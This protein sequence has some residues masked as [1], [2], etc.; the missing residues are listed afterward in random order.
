[1]QL[2]WHA[3]APLQKY[4][5]QAIVGTAQAPPLQA[6]AILRVAAPAGQLALAQA[7]PSAYFWQPPA[8]S[9]LPF[10]PQ[11]AAP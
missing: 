11:V 9:H 3:A 1:L 7:V 8:P 2:A 6:P 4:G 10:V 5:V